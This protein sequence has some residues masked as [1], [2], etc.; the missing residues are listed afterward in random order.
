VASASYLEALSH[1]TSTFSPPMVLL[2]KP[3]SYADLTR[4]LA[5]TVP[6]V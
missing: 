6:V 5:R 2:S 4:E 1:V 3:L